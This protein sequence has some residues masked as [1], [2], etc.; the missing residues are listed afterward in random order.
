MFP[1]SYT[2]YNQYLGSQRCCN[3][4]TP[5]P[6]GP[7]GPTGSGTIGPR[8]VTGPTGPPNGPTGPTGPSGNPFDSSGNLDI[9]CNLIVDVSGIYFCDGTYIGQG[10]SFDILANQ[11]LKITSIN[12]INFSATNINVNNCNLYVK[13]NNSLIVTNPTNDINTIGAYSQYMTNG[14]TFNQIEI[15]NDALQQWIIIRD[16]ASNSYSYLTYEDL[17]FNDVTIPGKNSSIDR[18]LLT[19]DDGAGTIGSYSK[20]DIQYNNISILPRRFYSS[21]SFSVSGSPSGTIFDL[22]SITDMTAGQRWK[23]E[24]SLSFD[25]ITSGYNANAIVS[26]YVANNSNSFVESEAPLGFSNGYYMTPNRYD[27]NNV[28]P[29]SKSMISFT[30][31]FLVGGITD[32][33]YKVVICGGT[34]DNSIW[35]GNYIAQVVLTYISN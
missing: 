17:T 22:G 1:K 15:N 24:V 20:N 32:A 27:P 16:G 33:P 7:Q 10:N 13:N 8:G 34:F 12:D 11:E 19:F 5:G 2:S 30:D 6:T 29:S 35:S 4:N 26:Y 3:F 28:T 21:G 31:S 25:A 14:S 23:I 9:S 18:D